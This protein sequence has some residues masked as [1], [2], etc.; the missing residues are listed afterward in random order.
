MGICGDGEKYFP[1]TENGDGDEE[2]I[3]GSGIEKHPPHIPY[4]VDIPK[5]S[6]EK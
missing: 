1:M 3:W 4:P 5:P 2:Q 6:A